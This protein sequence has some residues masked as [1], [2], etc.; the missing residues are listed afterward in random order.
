LERRASLNENAVNDMKQIRQLITIKDGRFDINYTL[1]RDTAGKVYV[2]TFESP[3][4]PFQKGGSGPTI[5]PDE[6]D[7]HVI[8]GRSLRE[9]VDEA[10]S[11]IDCAHA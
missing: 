10:I 8:D 1:V 9:I 6:F 5:R 3:N 2:E 11:R 7:A 4:K